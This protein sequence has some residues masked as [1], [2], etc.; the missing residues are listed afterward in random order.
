MRGEEEEGASERASGGEL[1]KVNAT[2]R[3]CARSPRVIDR[4]RA[5]IR[6]KMVRRRRRRRP[7]LCPR[8]RGRKGLGTGRDLKIMLLQRRQKNTHLFLPAITRKLAIVSRCFLP[9][10]LSTLPPSPGSTKFHS[11]GALSLPPI[12]ARHLCRAK[13]AIKARTNGKRGRPA[14]RTFDLGKASPNGTETKDERQY[15]KFYLSNIESND[16]ELSPREASGFR[17]PS[18]RIGFFHLQ[19]FFFPAADTREEGPSNFA[20]GEK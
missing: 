16:R 20:R 9:N 7:P 1:K 5:K 10:S 3:R 17:L 6:Q 12:P 14:G 8:R 11:G 15:R 19:N 4:V 2:R 18:L 13:I